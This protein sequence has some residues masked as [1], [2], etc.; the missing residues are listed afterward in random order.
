M[1][2]V[3]AASPATDRVRVLGRELEYKWVVAAASTSALFLVIPSGLNVEEIGK[4]MEREL[5]TTDATW[6][7]GIYHFPMYTTEEEYA[8]EYPRQRAAWGPVFDKYHLDMML[9]GHTHHY[10]RSG[11]LRDSKAVASPNDGTVYLVSAPGIYSTFHIT[12][13]RLEFKSLDVNGTVK[14]ELTIDKTK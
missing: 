5:A 12:A 3:S 2:V 7:F 11:P 9:T 4:W 8:N 13:N 1:S 10:V 6:K 14:D